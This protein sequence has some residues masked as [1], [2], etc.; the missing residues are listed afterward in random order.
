MSV[1]LY[2]F[3]CSFSAE[4]VSITEYHP[5]WKINL[6]VS[7]SISRLKRVYC[8]HDVLERLYLYDVSFAEVIMLENNVV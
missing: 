5:D 4:E 6:W 8:M 3:I 2:D 1:L 7:E